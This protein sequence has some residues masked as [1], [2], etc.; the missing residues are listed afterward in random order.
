VLEKK[1]DFFTLD[2]ACFGLKAGVI[3]FDFLNV[4]FWGFLPSR[5]KSPK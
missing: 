3:D 4:T 1:S 5:N 2:A